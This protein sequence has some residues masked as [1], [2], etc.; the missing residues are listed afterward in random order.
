M[1]RRDTK[2]G[3]KSDDWRDEWGVELHNT[4]FLAFLSQVMPLAIEAFA[5]CLTHQP[6]LN[7][8]PRSC[9]FFYLWAHFMKKLVNIDEGHIGSLLNRGARQKQEEK[10]WLPLVVLSYN[11]LCS[12]FVASACLCLHVNAVDVTPCT[13][14]YLHS[15]CLSVAAAKTPPPNH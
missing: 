6:A 15:L 2:W 1:R 14:L 8:S 4:C 3:K 5:F 11:E 13:R 7:F 9:S 10:R 12:V